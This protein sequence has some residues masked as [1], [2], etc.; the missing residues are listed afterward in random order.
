MCEA[1]HAC[2]RLVYRTPGNTG[3][4]FSEQIALGSPSISREVGCLEGLRPPESGNKEWMLRLYG[5]F[6]VEAA[7][8][9]LPAKNGRKRE[10]TGLRKTAVGA[11]HEVLNILVHQ[12]LENGVSVSTVHDRTLV[13]FIVARLLQKRRTKNG[14]ARKQQGKQK[15]RVRRLNSI[16]ALNVHL[17]MP[18]LLRDKGTPRA[19]P[20]CSRLHG[21]GPHLESL[22]LPNVLLYTLFD[23]NRLERGRM[24]WDCARY[25]ISSVIPPRAKIAAT[26]GSRIDDHTFPVSLMCSDSPPGGQATVKQGSTA[27]WSR[28]VK[29]CTITF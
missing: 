17:N 20:P 24:W 6:S 23:V 18:L 26:K 21:E 3:G 19:E 7:H 25:L 13:L 8:G 22:V 2:P 14:A 5:D 4:N 15:S 27:T 11:E 10:L 16:V 9:S 1:S 12:L 28:R 29:I